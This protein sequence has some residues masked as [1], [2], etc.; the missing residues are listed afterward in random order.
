MSPWAIQKP[1]KTEREQNRYDDKRET[2]RERVALKKKRRTEE[3]RKK[4]EEKK[5][6]LHDIDN[7]VQIN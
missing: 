3:R 6:I 4:S 1:G 7:F 5:V 2:E